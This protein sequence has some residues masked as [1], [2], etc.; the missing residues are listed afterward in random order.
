ML[1]LGV[2]AIVGYALTSFFTIED[3]KV[4]GDGVHIAISERTFPKNLLFFPVEQVRSALLRD[5]PLLATVDIQRKFPHTLVIAVTTRAPIAILATGEQVV[6]VARGGVV[7]S[8][9]PHQPLPVVRIDVGEVH[10]GDIIA[11]TRVL[12]SLQFLE[13]SESVPLAVSEINIVDSLS[14][15]AKTDT[16][17]IL[18]PQ[19]KDLTGL[20]ATLQTLLAGFRI[21][22][23]TPT[24]I[25]LRFDK[26]VVTF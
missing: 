5:Y 1:S 3:I 4:V 20:G 10:V 8:D 16:L 24:R 7:T 12:R 25:D 18:F 19:D 6:A 11:D 21:K 2:T 14:L 22:G 17:D 15:R 9:S 13:I 23:S 26:P